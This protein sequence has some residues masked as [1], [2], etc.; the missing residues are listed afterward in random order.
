MTPPDAWVPERGEV[1]W[2]EFDP[3]AGREQAGREQAGRRPAVVLSPAGYN[4]ATG[5]A[6][7]VPVTTKA[8]GY[9]FEVPL[10]P[11]CPVQGVAFADQVRC[12]DWRARHAR[13]V[14]MLPPAVLAGL[15]A[16]TR[17]LLE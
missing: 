13:P 12:L 15:L 2:L 14:A 7:C 5:R 1:V 10:P 4:G 3:Q 11:D 8:K 17:A 16:R 9:P 6:L